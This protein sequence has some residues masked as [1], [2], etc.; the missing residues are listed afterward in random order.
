MMQS[1]YCMLFWAACQSPGIEPE[2]DEWAWSL[3]PRVEQARPLEQSPPWSSF[4]ARIFEQ[5]PSPGHGVPGR[6]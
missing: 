5:P 4:Y 6:R 1:L 2:W 3:P